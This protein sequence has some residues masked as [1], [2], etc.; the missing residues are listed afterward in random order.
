MTLHQDF[1]D[2]FR[3]FGG[4]FE[5]A[6]AVIKRFGRIETDCPIIRVEQVAAV[7]FAEIGRAHV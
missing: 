1:L 7:D 4:F 3:A 6:T 2:R 5:G